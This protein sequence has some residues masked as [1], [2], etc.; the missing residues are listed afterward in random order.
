MGA[1]MFHFTCQKLFSTENFSGKLRKSS[2]FILASLSIGACSESDSVESSKDSQAPQVSQES[3]YYHV[4]NAQEVSFVDEYQVDRVYVGHVSAAQTAN[5]GFEHA[6]KVSEIKAEEG[7]FVAKGAVLARLD[8]QLLQVEKLELQAQLQEISADQALVEANLNRN[9]NLKKGGF[10][11]E[12]TLDELKARSQALSARYAR[13]NAALKANQINQDKSVLVA[14]FDGVVEQKHIAEGEVVAPGTPAF[15]LI[16]QSS[17]EVKIGV[18]VRI[19]KQVKNET[20]HALKIGDEWVNAQWAS[21]GAQIDPVSR[22]VQLRFLLPESEPFYNGQLAYLSIKE[23]VKKRGTW[24][25]LEALTDGVRGLW[26]VYVLTPNP[27]SKL[28][29]LMRRDVRVLHATE[30]DAFVTGALAAG[31]RLL[32][33]GLQRLVPGQ[34]VRLAKQ[35]TKKESSDIPSFVKVGE[36]QQADMNEDQL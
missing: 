11:S 23:T 34:Q 22:T 19:L 9:V 16:Q 26:N 36:L 29:T 24:I 3:S 2:L 31:D 4:A 1:K 6:G 7:R 20:V 35:D 17:P 21:G 13:I 8:S 30:T 12:Q 18:P 32:V 10:T 27:D 15:V 33:S 25:P 28:Y 14:P 5:V